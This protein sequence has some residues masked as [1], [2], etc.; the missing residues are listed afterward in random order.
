MTYRI[1]GTALDPQPT[2]GRWVQRNIFGRDGNGRAIYEPLRRFEMRWG[3]LNAE[4]FDDLQTYFLSI[5]STG[6]VIVDLPVYTTGTYSFRSY[7]GCY[8]DEPTTGPFFTEHYQDVL[9]LV[10]NIITDK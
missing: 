7:T 9:L 5:G 8:I 10:S 1:N 2:T 3:L 4:E 6:T